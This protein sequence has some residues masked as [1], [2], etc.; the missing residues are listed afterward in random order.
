MSGGYGP[1]GYPGHDPRNRRQAG[2]RAGFQGPGYGGQDFGG[3]GYGDQRYDPQA[4]GD[5]GDYGD[6]RG[7]GQQEGPDDGYPQGPAAG[8]HRRPPAGYGQRGYDDDQRGYDD[9]QRDDSFLPGFDGRG[10]Y[11]GRG[12]DRKS[13]V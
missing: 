2:P 7:Y 5:Y 4:H 13:V 11:D 12:G 8:G 10:G 3:A 6:P 9:G 1:G